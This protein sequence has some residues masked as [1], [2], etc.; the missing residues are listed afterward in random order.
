MWKLVE[1]L[2]RGVGV[3]YVIFNK[4]FFFFIVTFISV[5]DIPTAFRLSPEEFKAKYGVPKPNVTDEN[6]IFHCQ[7]GRRG[8]KAVTEVQQLGFEK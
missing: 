1:G 3:I 7:S 5:G 4:F 8:K 2:C 6:L